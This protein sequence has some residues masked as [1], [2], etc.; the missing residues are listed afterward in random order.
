MGMRNLLILTRA[1]I[2]K[3]YRLRLTWVLL[4]LLIVILMMRVNNAYGHAFDPPPA[5]EDV[6]VESLVVLPQDYRRAAVLP[7]V[8]ERARL[9]F[10]WVNIFVI[11]LT[12]VTLGQEFAQ[13]T[14]RTALARGPGRVR[15]LLSKFTAL[16]AAAA[17]Y[18]AALWLACGILGLFTTPNLAGRV[19]WGFFDG[20]FLASEIAALARTW[21][22]TWPVIALTMLLVVWARS[23]GLSI[24]LAGLAYFLNWIGFASFGLVLIFIIEATGASTDQVA[25]GLWGTLLTLIPHY[26]SALVIHWGQ[27]GKLSQIDLGAFSTAQAFGLPVDPWRGLAVLLGYGLLALALA[28]WVFGRKDVAA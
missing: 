1:E 14:M 22:I 12:A 10:D 11:L 15:L 23:P 24:N 13:G 2:V 6:L 27:P 28:A 19:D 21:V 25:T 18:L 5:Q 9:S 17:F 8:F 4:G 3:L 20:P 7:G 26:N 16:A